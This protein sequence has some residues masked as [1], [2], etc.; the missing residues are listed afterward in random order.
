MFSW[1]LAS[2]VTASGQAV[3]LCDSGFRAFH[4][5]Y[6]L[7]GGSACSHHGAEALVPLLMGLLWCNP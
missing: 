5:F 1:L 7:A 2:Q 4:Q 6:F 3:L